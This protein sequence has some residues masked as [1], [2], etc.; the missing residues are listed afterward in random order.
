M[1]KE[2]ADILK[3]YSN[4]KCLFCGAGCPMFDQR[5]YDDDYYMY[6]CANCS[7]HIEF[8]G[9]HIEWFYI[10]I[11]E[12]ISAFIKSDSN[13]ANLCFENDSLIIPVISFGTSEDFVL[14]IKKL[15]SNSCLL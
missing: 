11:T 3:V 6:A 15:R 9:N 8:E 10:S 5:I 14:F 1:K 7:L 4:G 13:G 2:E 12:S